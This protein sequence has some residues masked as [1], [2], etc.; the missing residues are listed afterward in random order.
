M[1]SF[2]Q[3]RQNVERQRSAADT[4]RAEYFAQRWNASLEI[5]ESRIPSGRFEQ[6]QWLRALGKVVTEFGAPKNES[7]AIAHRNLRELCR[8]NMLALYA[9]MPD[10]AAGLRYLAGA[11]SSLAPDRVSAHF[12]AA[13]IADSLGPCQEG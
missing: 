7:D 5:F 10:A 12:I 1:P 13:R 3:I 11:T 8:L 4:G 9:R 6:I 2:G